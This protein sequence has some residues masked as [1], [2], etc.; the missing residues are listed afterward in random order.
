MASWHFFMASSVVCSLSFWSF[1]SEDAVFV[2][3]YG[4][5]AGVVVLA[6]ASRVL[7]VVPRPG[8]G[9]PRSSWGSRCRDRARRDRSDPCPRR[10]ARRARR[11]A[12]PGRSPRAV[13]ARGSGRRERRARASVRARERRGR[14]RCSPRSCRSSC[15]GDPWTGHDEGHADVRLERRLLA[16]PERWSRRGGSRCRR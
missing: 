16:A 6:L 9:G 13:A 3:S 7:D 10:G 5:V 4:S 14:G 12:S 2:S 1:G 15:R 8:A 11:C